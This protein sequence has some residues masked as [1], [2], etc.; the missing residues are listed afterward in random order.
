[1][2]DLGQVVWKLFMLIYLAP[3]GGRTIIIRVHVRQGK[4]GMHV[5]PSRISPCITSACL[6]DRNDG[7]GAGTD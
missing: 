4:V 6:R 1:M 2:I 5:C 7:P 3:P